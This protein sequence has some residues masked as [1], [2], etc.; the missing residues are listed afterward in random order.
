MP[1]ADG[2]VDPRLPDGRAG[3]RAR[4]GKP[5]GPGAAL[6]PHSS[7]ALTGSFSVNKLERGPHLAVGAEAGKFGGK[8]P[9][10]DLVFLAEANRPDAVLFLMMGAAKADAKRIVRLARYSRICGA[11]KMGELYRCGGAM[12]DTAPVRFD[13]VTM[14]WPHS[15]QRGPDSHL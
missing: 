8:R 13:P 7:I 14:A 12:G 4:P 10:V 5:P 6:Q 1:L 15:L 9:E 2:L 11:A 3:V